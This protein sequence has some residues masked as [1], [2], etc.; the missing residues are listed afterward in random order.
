MGIR[1][2]EDQRALDSYQDDLDRIA[3][4]T[5]MGIRERI[6][7]V[8]RTSKNYV[9]DVAKLIESEAVARSKADRLELIQQVRAEHHQMRP[10][11]SEWVDMFN[12]IVD[13][14]NAK[15]DAAQK[16]VEAEG[17]PND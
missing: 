6:G 13:E 2:Q 3:A 4:E 9:E 11:T 1:E 5:P 12:A 15:L 8:F 16:E 10:G 7:R 14:V 17:V